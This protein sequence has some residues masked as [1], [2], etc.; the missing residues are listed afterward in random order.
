[1]K[2]INLFLFFSLNQS[3]AEASDPMFNELLSTLRHEIQRISPPWSLRNTHQV[4]SIVNQLCAYKR[5]LKFI[6]VFFFY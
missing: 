5:I 4:K 3:V 6:L 1:M 2:F